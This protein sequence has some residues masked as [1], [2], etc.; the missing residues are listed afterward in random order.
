MWFIHGS[1]LTFPVI[2]SWIFLFFIFTMATLCWETW[3]T[4]QRSKSCWA[5]DRKERK[6]FDK[7][8]I[9]I[10]AL[11]SM[12]SQGTSA[13]SSWRKD[14][15]EERRLFSRTAAGNRVYISM[16]TDWFSY[17]SRSAGPAVFI[18]WSTYFMT[19]P[20]YLWTFSR[21]WIDSSNLVCGDSKYR[22]GIIA[23]RYYLHKDR[24]LNSP[25]VNIAFTV[26]WGLGYVVI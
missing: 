14:F 12:G 19:S 17:L 8:Y 21:N 6:V 15:G 7:D 20:R 22:V 9:K 10:P 3:M 26:L 2:L 25:A 23:V 16:G 5:T 18:T 4:C 11:P 1:Q 13:L 24:Y